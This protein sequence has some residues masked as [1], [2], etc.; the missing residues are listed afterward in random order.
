MQR[1][2][3]LF[4]QNEWRVDEWAST[5]R[6]HWRK[7]D[8]LLHYLKRKRVFEVY[9]KKNPSFLSFVLPEDEPS[10]GDVMLGERVNV[11][12]SDNV[13]IHERIAA[14]VAFGIDRT[15]EVVGFELMLFDGVVVDVS[16]AGVRRRKLTRLRND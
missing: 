7:K 10:S 16:L 4:E 11:A 15:D 3:L 1:N 8:D 9:E 12:V 14:T 5:I 13:S 2:I 6:H